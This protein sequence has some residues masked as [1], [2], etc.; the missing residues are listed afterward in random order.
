MT[1]ARTLEPH[2]T[3]R[4]LDQPLRACLEAMPDP[5]A[6]YAAVRTGPAAR[7]P[8]HSPAP[9]APGRADSPGG[10]IVDFEI[11][12]VNDAACADLGVARER[13]VGN[14]LCALFP[15]I[16]TSGCFAIFEQVALTGVAYSEDGFALEHRYVDLRVSRLGDGVI[17]T[18]HDVTSRK[19]LELQLQHSNELLRAG[20][21]ELTVLMD[22]TPA[23]VWIATD[24]DCRQIRGSRLAH[25]LLRMPHTSNLTVT[26][27]PDAPPPPAH[28]TVWQDGRQLTPDELPVQ[29]AARGEELRNFEEELVFDDGERLWLFGNAMPLRNPDGS[30]RGAIAAF[31]DISGY[32]RAEQELRVANDAKDQFLATISHELR[33]PLTAVMGYAQMLQNG[34]ITPERQARVIDTISRNAAL[35]LQLIDDILDV[36]GIIR[37]K[38]VLGRRPVDLPSVLETAITTVM[39]TAGRKGVAVECEIAP[40]T[41]TVIGDEGRLHQILGNVLTNGVKFTPPGGSVRAALRGAAG[42]VEIEI[43]DTGIGMAAEFLPHAFDRFTQEGTGTTREHGGLGIGLHI[44]HYLV[45][46]HG[47]TIT[48]HSEGVGAGA[49][50]RIVLPL[51]ADSPAMPDGA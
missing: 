28:F 12:L 35:Q 8:V 5:F 22:A 13:Q 43:S 14:R 51:K 19:Q 30:P 1:E 3:R 23:T 4:L 20:A 9:D 26:P 50:F 25:E 41:W 11:V 2:D 48:A 32:K 46:C 45:T 31:V 17:V 34:A 29:R 36:S 16:R 15:F 49:T 39:P 33:T 6:A 24:P 37:G 44:A 21:E 38:L 18:W 40:G 7:G 42:G 47:G 10:A 27:S